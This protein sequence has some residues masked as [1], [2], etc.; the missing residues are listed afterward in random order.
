[1]LVFRWSGRNQRGKIGVHVNFDP[2]LDMTPF[3]DS[4]SSSYQSKACDD[5]DESRSAN[6]ADS[7][8]TPPGGGCVY[9]LRAVVMHHG[10]GFGRGHYTAYCFNEEAGNT[11]PSPILS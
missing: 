5:D 6:A 10:R 7:G 2:E 4:S 11:P 9:D 3:T 8:D 1:M